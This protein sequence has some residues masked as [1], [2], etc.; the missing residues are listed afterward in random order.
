M[1][2][3]R[4][5]HRCWNKPN[6]ILKE[7]TRSKV[8]AKEREEIKRYLKGE[9]DSVELDRWKNYDDIWNYD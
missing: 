5:Q 4:N 7:L 9:V 6:Q 2:R 3:S 8:R 1:S